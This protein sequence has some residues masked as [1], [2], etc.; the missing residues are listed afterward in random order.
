MGR[1]I[2]QLH[3]MAQNLANKLVDE[4]A[5]QG[6]AIKITDCFRTVAE[7]NELYAQGR[8][9]P[10]QIVTNAKGTDY[11]SHH[12]WGTAFDFCRND[13]KGAYNES[14]NFF[15]KVG[16]ICKKLGLEWGGDWKSP[17]DK[18]HFQ[19][20]DWGSTTAKLKQQY[21]TPDRFKETWY[22]DNESGEYIVK[23]GDTLSRIANMFGTSVDAIAKYNNIAD[24]NKISVG[25]VIKNPANATSSKEEY[26]MPA[27]KKGSRGKAV[28][29][30]QIIVGVNADGIFGQATETATKSFQ[31]KVGIA[32]DGIVGKNSWR[33]GLESVG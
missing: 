8:T 16:Q 31:K 26:D 2:K 27:I 15:Y 30:W 10:G 6:L 1:D 17:V 22:A 21:S 3:P 28:K 32:Q 29:I 4:C 18:P 25:Q 14:G 12:M 33:Y 5:K 13:G 9:K 24:V 23:S 19:L 7:Q 20:P 11:Q